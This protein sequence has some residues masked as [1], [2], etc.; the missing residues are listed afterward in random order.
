MAAHP[1]LNDSLLQQE[2]VLG[3]PSAATASVTATQQS[4][5]LAPSAAGGSPLKAQGQ[6]FEPLDK[7]ASQTVKVSP[8]T[9]FLSISSFTIFGHLLVLLSLILLRN[10]K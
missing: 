10:S 9:K 2:D 3:T 5:T 1:P 6:P 4:A 7:S 8:C